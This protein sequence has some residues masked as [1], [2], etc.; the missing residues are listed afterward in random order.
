MTEQYLV[1]A[2]WV[3]ADKYC[4]DTG[5]PMETVT[6]R[7]RAGIW[8]SGKHY[9]RLSQRI[10]MINVPEVTAW[11]DRQPHVEAACPKG[12]K[13]AKERAAAA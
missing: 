11:I 7:I 2:V 12:L 8:A 10:L 6:A 9:K 5:E 4:A 1:A 3:R 13:S